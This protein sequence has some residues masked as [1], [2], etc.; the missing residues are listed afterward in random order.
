M[1][2]FQKY[3]IAIAVIILTASAAA[4]LNP[5]DELWVAAAGRGA[6]EGTSFWVTDLY[7]M[8]LE[9]EAVTVNIT[10]LERG[11]DNTGAVPVDFEIDPSATL[12][13]E[14]V[15]KEVF[16]FDR[17]WGGLHVEI[18]DGGGDDGA[19]QTTGG[20]SQLVVEARVYSLAEG[21]ET[22]GL[23]FE[24]I[25]SFAAISSD[26]PETTHSIGA[27]DNDDYRSNWYGVNTTE[28]TAEVMVELLDVDGNVLAS[29][30]FT[31]PPFAPILEPVGDLGGPDFTTGTVRFTMLEGEGIFGVTKIDD[32]S[33]DSVNLESHWECADDDEAEFTTEFFI[34][35]CT[36][37]TTGRNPYWIPLVPGY[38]LV[39]QGEEDGQVI[40]LTVT[41]LDETMMVDGVETRVV[42]EYETADDEIVEISR[43]Y[44]AFCTETK[45][46][47][48]FGEDV[49][50]YENGEVVSHDGAWRA[51]VDGAT[52][53]VVMPGTVL[54]GSRYY[55]EIAPGVAEDRAE[56]ISMDDTAETEAGTF[57]NCLE[58][59]ETTP[60]VPGE[61]SLKVYAP[62]IGLVIDNAVDL[63]DFTDPDES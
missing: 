13:L 62:G 33:N 53:G 12:V 5:D 21:G 63:V 37:A 26:G 32:A 10:W 59:W 31:M 2:R 56:H 43:N 8:N 18:A 40:D 48:Y 60:L 24:G 58:V 6:G 9:E 51:G 27:G 35:D 57:E 50:I 54:L 4:A 47:F 16:G 15:V 29:D 45:S 44:F 25:P 7:V 52:A 46:V 3:L 38:E 30:D 49:D 34:D 20:T 61:L 28:E 14:D 23:G 1:M 11:A 42:Q 55:Q 22:F 39:F 17:A 41:V 19:K 36:F